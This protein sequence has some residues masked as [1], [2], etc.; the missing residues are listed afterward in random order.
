VDDYVPIQN[1]YSYEG[2]AGPW[3][4]A[5]LR[6]AF[7]KAGELEV[8][9]T[10]HGL[11]SPFFGLGMGA[12][13]V[14]N[15]ET[16]PELH[17]SSSEVWTL[18]MTKV[19]LLNRKDDILEGGK[20]ASNRRWKLWSVVLTGSQLLFFR[21]PSWST[22]LLAQTVLSDGHVIFPQHVV[23]KPDE[24][25]SVKDAVAVIDRSYIKV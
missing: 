10:D 21:D 17:A 2:T 6:L 12:S 5:K 14:G 7:A 11:M 20:K 13:S 23:L 19:G 16:S 4:E 8:G 25:L 3:D 22:S 18:K 15:T 24:V 1:P 9:P